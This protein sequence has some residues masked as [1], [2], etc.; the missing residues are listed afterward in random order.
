MIVENKAGAAGNIAAEAVARAAPDGYTLVVVASSHATNVNLYSKLSYDPVKDFA[1]VSLLTTNFFVVA[2]PA[3][4]P[5]N[6]L[7]ELIALAKTKKGGINYGSAGAGQGNHLG[8][9]L[10]KVRGGFDATHVPYTGIGPATV[11]LLGEQIDVSLLTPPGAVPHVKTGK[12]KILAMT[13]L[14]RSPLMPNVPTVA[15]SG[16]PGYEL[17]GWIGLLAPA[18]TPKEIVDKLQQAVAKVLKEPDVIGKLESVM[19]EPVGSTPQDFA[20]FLQAEIATW[21]KVIKQSG[22]KAE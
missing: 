10:L 14:K 2:V 17:S 1:P 22:A 15:E 8:M 13:G 7:G 19:A 11:A 6:T 5:A 9:E 20:S 21:G 12:L 16:F 4:S 18:G 3:S